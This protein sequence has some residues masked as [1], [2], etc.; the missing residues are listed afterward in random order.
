[1]QHRRANCWRLLGAA[2]LRSDIKL[3]RRPLAE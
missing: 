3:P 1:M 2:P